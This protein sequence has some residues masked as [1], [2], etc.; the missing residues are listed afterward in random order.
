MMHCTI[1]GEDVRVGEPH[2]L[3]SDN[4]HVH[5]ACADRNAA[6]AW[7]GRQWRALAHLACI[8]TTLATFVLTETATEWQAL[9]LAALWLALHRHLHQRWW[10]ITAGTLWRR[11][12]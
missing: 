11:Q 10:Q 6:R 1:C 3:A 4:T 7:R 8:A 9:L 2:V 5:I 12:R